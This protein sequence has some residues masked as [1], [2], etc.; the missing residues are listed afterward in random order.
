MELFSVHLIR[1][2][3]PKF[4]WPSNNNWFIF[5]FLQSLSFSSSVS[6]PQCC[7]SSVHE[8]Y[9]FPPPFFLMFWSFYWNGVYEV[10][11]LFDRLWQQIMYILSDRT[12][13][14]RKWILSEQSR[15]KV[16]LQGLNWDSD[17]TLPS[18]RTEKQHINQ[19]LGRTKR[20]EQGWFNSTIFTAYDC[21]EILLNSLYQV[22]TIRQCFG[23][24][25]FR[26]MNIIPTF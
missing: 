2:Y 5:T 23:M 18:E 26:N 21:V 7:I 12:L 9:G 19:I 3:I 20:L 8:M 17:F 16:R 4:A 13:V 6:H 10:N 22:W 15:S 11:H 25:L 24:L 1:I 14:I